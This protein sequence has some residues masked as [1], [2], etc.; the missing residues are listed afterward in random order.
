MAFDEKDKLIGFI[1]GLLIG[2]T[3]GSLFTLLYAPK[4]GKKLRR[5]IHRRSLD[6]GDDLVDKLKELNKKSEYLLSDTEKKIQKI[7]SDGETVV[8]NLTKKIRS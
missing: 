7:I 8:S 3:I 5:D 6:L 1:E 2:G 4:S